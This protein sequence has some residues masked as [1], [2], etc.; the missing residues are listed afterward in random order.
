M[1]T[2]LSLESNAI[3]H[4]DVN[5]QFDKPSTHYFQIYVNNFI[6]IQTFFGANE[7]WTF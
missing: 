2:F 6:Y 5:M 3:V 7:R 4:E 1:Y